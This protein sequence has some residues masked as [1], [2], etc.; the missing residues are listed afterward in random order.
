MTFRSKFN[1]ASEGLILHNTLAVTDQGMPLGL[2]D[3][4]FI[5]RTSFVGKNAR[6]ARK[7]RHWNRSIDQK[8]S[9]RWINVVKTCHQIEFGQ[10]HIVHVA[11]RECDLYE[12]Y[13]DANELQEN[14]LVRAS[15]NRSINKRYRRSSPTCLLFDHLKAK[16]A[17]GKV[18]ITIQVNRKKKFRQT[19]L[20]I[21]YCPITMPPPPNKTIKKNGPHLPL[22]PLF[23]IMA[24]ERRPP[25]NQKWYLLGVTD[26]PRCQ[27]AR[28]SH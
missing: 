11:D 8:E 24:I 7:I 22:V 13:R 23:A 4:R 2:E 18:T 15:Q 19:E 26:Q 1:H 27:Y 25:R 28:T 10:A 17:Q 12:F 20:S 5:K 6:E 3:Q 9:A 14:I 21:V 16:K